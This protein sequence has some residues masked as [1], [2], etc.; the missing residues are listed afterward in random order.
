MRWLGLIVA[1][2]LFGVATAE[3]QVVALGDSQTRGYLLPLSDAWPAKLEGL[4]HQRGIKVSVAN[5]GVNGDTSD[6]MLSRL[7]SAVPSG[8]RV[9]ILMCCGNDNKDK[10]H[11]VADHLGNVT[12]MVTRL[13]ARGIAVVYSAARGVAYRGL[14]NAGAAAARSA[15]ALWCGE[16]YQGLPPEDKED[17]PAG[18][19]PTPS[20]HD[21][22]AA[23]MLPC[24]LRALGR[25]G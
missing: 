10:R 15:G 8:T 14:D 18:V 3:A 7:D 9:V 5:E 22:I 19:H 2:T 16:S 17:S 4:L 23:R 6:G 13:R 11:I 12:A 21:K 1:L 20:G 24:V 25:S